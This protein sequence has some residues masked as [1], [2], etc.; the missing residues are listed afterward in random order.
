MQR[1]PR[2]NWPPGI[3]ID[4][5]YWHPPPPWFDHWDTCDMRPG[6]LDH[7]SNSTDTMC[8]YH[9]RFA[10]SFLSDN[11]YNC[12]CHIPRRFLRYKV[13]ISVSPQIL[14]KISLLNTY[15]KNFLTHCY[16]SEVDMSNM[17]SQ[18]PNSM[19][20]LYK[21]NEQLLGRKKARWKVIAMAV[22][23]ADLLV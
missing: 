2:W 1:T 22:L 11:W 18:K 3:H 7:C 17:H 5:H 15:K 23:T 9:L 19:W 6:P 13:C 20:F 4:W 14:E 12:G 8:N 10:K 16:S 21:P